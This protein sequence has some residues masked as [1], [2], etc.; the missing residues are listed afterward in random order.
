MSRRLGVFLKKCLYRAYEKKCS[1]IGH[2]FKSQNPKLFFHHLTTF[3]MFIMKRN[4]TV[5]SDVRHTVKLGAGEA[6]GE[7]EQ[8]PICC[9][10]VVPGEE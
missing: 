7:E 1:R 4:G 9:T 6:V 5:L 10:A 3:Q 2:V 8:V